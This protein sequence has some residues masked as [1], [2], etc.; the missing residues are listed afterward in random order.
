ME[1]IRIKY[2]GGEKK[3]KGLETYI[4][5]VKK[6]N[7][8]CNCKSNKND[9]GC[10]NYNQECSTYD[11]EQSCG[12]KY[13]KSNKCVDRDPYDECDDDNP[14]GDFDPEVIFICT[15]NFGPFGPIGGVPSF[16]NTGIVPN[17]AGFNGLF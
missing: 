5:Y 6:S 15:G 1:R 2:G 13:R 17:L 16:G 8:N 3:S 4:D 14:Y 12:P 11:D 10:N 9:C 7:C